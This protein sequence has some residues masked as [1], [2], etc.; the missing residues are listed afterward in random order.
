MKETFSPWLP[1]LLAC[2]PATL[3]LWL[4]RS[5]DDQAARR[6]GRWGTGLGL[7]LA[8]SF[9]QPLLSQGARRAHEATLQ[10]GP[11]TLRWLLDS[12][13]V[14][15]LLLAGVLVFAVML[16]AP[17]VQLKR[18]QVRRLL[19]VHALVTVTLLTGDAAVLAVS[20]AL[21]IVPVVR[22]V[23]P[24]GPNR[25]GLL[26]VLLAYH[27][28]SI[29]CF[30]AAMLTLGRYQP[31]SGLLGQSL[32][33][34]SSERVPLAFHPWLFGLL[35]VATFVRMGICPLHSWIPVTFERGNATAF[36]LF[37]ALQTDV[38]LFTRLTIP[39][40]A[41]TA[42]LALPLM[43]STALFTAMYGALAALGQTNLLRIVGF[44]SVSQAG[45]ML[46]G[47]VFG[48][49][50]AASGTLL[51]WLASSGALVGMSLMVGALYARTGRCDMRDFGGLVS[52][53]PALST[54]FFL[55]GLA[56]I[57]IPGTVTFAAEDM[58]IHGT[59]QAHP[60]LTLVMITA[61]VIN[62]I[63]VVR[64]YVLTFLGNPHPNAEPL[65]QLQD[66]RPRER[67]MAAMLLLA[68][69]GAGLVPG[70]IVSVQTAAA[71]WLTTLERR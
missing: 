53:A 6:V 15:P 58:L 26:R 20:W 8:G 69:F 29:G 49:V 63:A 51:Y 66:L 10:L 22:M 56:T 52:Q 12:L 31:S 24:T 68:L 44:W 50:H 2:W 47:L 23:L 39:L 25:R 9:V 5:R 32:V 18:Q 34:L 38:Y 35:T 41:H 30:A 61:M 46:T 67:W 3:A 33:D 71:Q 14:L 60:L 27:G 4:G 70:P 19:W 21:L 1:L 28:L 45:L 65:G 16:G 36:A 59:L 55:F 54:C 42:H 17:H 40:F 43:V 7:A 37:A 11:V 48:D 64:V 62:A 57:A 13:N